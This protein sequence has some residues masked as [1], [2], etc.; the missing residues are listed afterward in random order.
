MSEQHEELI[1]RGLCVAFQSERVRV[2][3]ADDLRWA[4]STCRGAWREEQIWNGL[5]N[6]RRGVLKRTHLMYAAAKGDAAR[7]R[8]LLDRGAQGGINWRDADGN[9]ALHHAVDQVTE[10][11]EVVRLLLDAGALP[12]VHNNAAC[13]GRTPFIAAAARGRKVRAEWKRL[14]ELRLQLR[15]RP[16]EHDRDALVNVASGQHVC[17]G[18]GCSYL[19]KRDALPTQ[20]CSDARSCISARELVHA[21]VR[22]GRCYSEPLERV[23]SIDADTPKVSKVARRN[24]TRGEIAAIGTLCARLAEQRARLVGDERR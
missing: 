8:W 24:T 21:H 23:E 10:N 16:H 19:L 12:N 22:T 17:D 1:L 13:R 20:R 18:T 14:A 5:V 2:G 6:V 11:V 7:V 3:F 4:A 9:T 15:A